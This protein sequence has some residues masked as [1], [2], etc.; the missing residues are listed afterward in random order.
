MWKKPKE[1]TVYPGNGYENAA[2]GVNTP[3]AAVDAW[4]NSAP[5]NDV[6]LNQGIWK[7]YPWGSVGAGMQGGYAVVWFGVEADPGR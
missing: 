3:G 1:L 5:H 7:D 2:A 6:M 4:K